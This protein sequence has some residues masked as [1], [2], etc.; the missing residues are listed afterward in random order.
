MIT[1]TIALLALIA[2]YFL[3]GRFVEGHAVARIFED[4][5]TDDQRQVL[6][7]RREAYS[8]EI[9]LTK[10]KREVLVTRSRCYRLNPFRM[11]GGTFIRNT[12]TNI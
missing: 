8:R 6:A 1:F 12:N 7:D 5:G 2:G 10:K 3:Y 11:I 4:C 9:V